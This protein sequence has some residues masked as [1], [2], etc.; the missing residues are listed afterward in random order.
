VTDGGVQDSKTGFESGCRRL[1]CGYIAW[2]M[3]QVVD[4]SNLY[5]AEVVP[6]SQ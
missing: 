1:F 2:K 5:T 6:V 4:G 3:G